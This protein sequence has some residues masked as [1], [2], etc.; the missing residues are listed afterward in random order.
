MAT[1]AVNITGATTMVG[2]TITPPFVTTDSFTFSFPYISQDDF[3]IDVNSETTLVAADYEFVSDYLIQLT[4]VGVAKLQGLY[5]AETSVPMVIRRRTT[6]DSKLVDF[7]DGGS[8]E[9]ADLDLISTQLFYLIQESYDTAEIGNVEFNPV[10]GTI[11]FDEVTINVGEPT[12]LSSATTLN[13][14]Y[15]NVVTPDY[16][17]AGV[18]R[19]G[20]L[21]FYSGDL[22]RANVDITSAAAVFVPSQWD[23]ILTAAQLAQIATNTA[24]IGTNTTD[25]GTN[26]TNIGTNVTNIGT[27]VTN[28]GTN[29]TDIGTNATNL[30]NHSADTSTH[31]VAELVGTT[32]TQDLSGKTFTDPITLQE[33]GS[34]PSTPATGDKK[35][36]PKTDGKLY[37]LD[38]GG[39]ETEVG[40]AGGADGNDLLSNQLHNIGIL[41]TVAASALT[42][43]LKQADGST[44]ADG[45]D[46]ARI[47]FRD[48]VATVGGFNSRSVTTSL[49][50]VIPSGATMGQTSTEEGRLYVYAVDNA[51]TVE[52]AVSSSKHWDEA[53][54][55]TTT[56]L[57][58]GADD[59]HLLYSTTARTSKPIRLI[60]VI[61]QTQTT[62]GTWATS[63]TVQK[64]GPI[65]P[66]TQQV[67]YVKDVKGA[68]VNGGTFTSGA[69]RTRDLNT[70][71]GDSGF[72]TLG[73][74]QFTLPSGEYDIDAVAQA[75][76]VDGHLTKLRNITDSTDDIIGESSFSAS[77]IN[78]GDTKSHL[79]GRIV[80]TASKT[81]ELQHRCETTSASTE[82]FGRGWLAGFSAVFTTIKITKI[83]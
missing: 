20:R 26:T 14:V 71:E 29:V 43:A 69:W 70:I 3:Q 30:T 42:V 49:S 51:G 75:I 7:S 11:D 66:I 78:A 50:L 34:T 35:I 53:D 10:D 72:I 58:T 63:P 31:G 52:L 28:I 18:Y 17:E 32:E 59:S 62:A 73:T 39:V 60:G 6:L 47:S 25:I 56:A 4:T 9:E 24:D 1:V 16:A 37:T 67:G 46:F 5:S 45:T 76:R 61:T 22:Y 15:N 74:N 44:D 41:G 36:Y 21:V 57:S 48:V 54:L 65:T 64:V 8:L 2:F 27:N 19:I 40:G 77:A 81:F 80:L 33:Q 55:Q 23:I 82:G 12:S 68:T 13:S 79:K 83:R 38:D